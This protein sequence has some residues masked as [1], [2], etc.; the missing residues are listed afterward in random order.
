MKYQLI[1]VVALSL[2]SSVTL[3]KSFN[4]SEQYYLFL[5]K[6]LLDKILSS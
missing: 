1:I 6:S 5:E 2:V 4:I 3:S